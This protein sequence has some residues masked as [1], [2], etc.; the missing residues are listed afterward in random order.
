MSVSFFVSHLKVIL[1]ITFLS[2]IWFLFT[3][4]VFTATKFIHSLA[5]NIFKVKEYL[6]AS[7]PG[8][9]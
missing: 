2:E 9:G 3:P 4:D 5:R 8:T 6:T 1:R 7:T